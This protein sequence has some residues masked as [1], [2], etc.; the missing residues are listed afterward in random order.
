MHNTTHTPLASVSSSTN[1][2][3]KPEKIP[4]GA[5][6][7]MTS[8][9]LLCLGEHRLSPLWSTLQFTEFSLPVQFRCY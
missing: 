8:L 2:I 7:A 1:L 5:K 4:T 3:E 9:G 6:E